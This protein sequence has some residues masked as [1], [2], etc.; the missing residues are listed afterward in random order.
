[1]ISRKYVVKNEAGLHLRPA[2]KLA[3][4]AEQCSSRTELL[5]KN[6]IINAKSILNIVSASIRKDDELVIRCT[7]PGEEEDLDKIVSVL[8]NLQ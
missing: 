5:Y 6:S 4:A 3:K 2:E 8:Q 7:G 1:M